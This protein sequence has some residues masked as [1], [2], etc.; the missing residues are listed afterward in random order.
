MIQKYPPKLNGH[1]D[2]FA[3]DQICQIVADVGKVVS[4]NDKYKIAES[5]HFDN[6]Q[7][8]ARAFESFDF[9]IFDWCSS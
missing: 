5:L 8:I 6:F 3:Y 2:G 4:M 7:A 1:L 9:L